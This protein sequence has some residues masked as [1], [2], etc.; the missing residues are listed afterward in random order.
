M[1]DAGLA[2]FIPDAEALVEAH[3]GGDGPQAVRVGEELEDHLPESLVVG[4]PI[5]AALDLLPGSL[6]ELVV[7][8]ARWAG[9]DAGH[10][11]EAE[12]PVT[13]HLII[14]GLLG[15]A[16]V[17]KV[18]APAR[19]VHLLPE[20]DVGRARR[21]AET[22]VDA[23]VYEV[24][25]GRVMVVE[26]GERVGAAL[27]PGLADGLLDGVAR[28]AGTLADV[29]GASGAYGP[30]H[31]LIARRALGVTPLGRVRGAVAVLPAGTVAFGH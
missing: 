22:A 10:A 15:E 8:H 6:D 21:K 31:R 7:L 19:R 4:P 3:R 30:C 17:H 13:N 26:S 23:V 9:R 2:Q 29:L 5:V 24:L 28:G 14:H 11:P 27:G 20:E 12:V 16:L 18:D 25:L 1:H